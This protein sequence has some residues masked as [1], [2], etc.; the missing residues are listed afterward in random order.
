M[1]DD[2]ADKGSFFTKGCWLSCS[3][4]SLLRTRPVA[5]LSSAWVFW[6]GVG[7]LV[8]G[9]LARLG[10][11]R[12]YVVHGFD[13]LDEVT[14]TG[15][16]LV[17]EVQEG[18]IRQRT[19]DPGDFALP[20]A[21]PDDLKGGDTARN[22]DIARARQILDEDHYDLKDVKERILEQLGVLRLNPEAKA[23]I[24]CFFGP[25]SVAVAVTS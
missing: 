19:L 17:F 22:L 5:G 13:G 21:T 24:L 6:R 8:A 18:Q 15:P 23:P 2:C 7:A 9:A 20:T 4:R 14:T 11:V 10:M 1:R 25:G 16:T 12:G 3:G